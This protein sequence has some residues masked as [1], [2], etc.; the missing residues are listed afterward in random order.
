MPACGQEGS[1]QPWPSPLRDGGDDADG[2]VRPNNGNTTKWHHHQRDLSTRR[3][4]TKCIDVAGVSVGCIASDEISNPDSPP[5]GHTRQ[6]W[7]SSMSHP[8]TLQSVENDVNH[9]LI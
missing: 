3:G 5:K 7:M 8:A 9:I 2:S 1:L 6:L 4:T